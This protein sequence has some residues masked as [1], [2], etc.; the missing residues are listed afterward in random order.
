MVM[1]RAPTLATASLLSAL[2]LF[3]QA[4]TN[5]EVKMTMTAKIVF[6]DLNTSLLLR[7][8]GLTAHAPPVLN[9]RS[10]FITKFSSVAQDDVK[11]LRCRRQGAAAQSSR[12]SCEYS[13]DSPPA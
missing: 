4:A 11:S 2:L 3:L 10:A 7:K 13:A 5:R 1:S 9:L 12:Q 6:E 8:I